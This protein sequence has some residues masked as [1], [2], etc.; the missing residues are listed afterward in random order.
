[1]SQKRKHYGADE[2]VA[3]LKQ[4]LVDNVPV[5][6]LCD[7]YGLHPTM[8]YQWQKRFF[9]NGAAAFANGKDT[10]K[11]RLEKKLAALED[12]LTNRNE[13]IAELMAEHTAL[14]KTLGKT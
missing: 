3:I 7:R 2:K 8:F 5:S 12:R 1:M 4:H 11:A 9:E 14:K 6:D 10:E 13:V